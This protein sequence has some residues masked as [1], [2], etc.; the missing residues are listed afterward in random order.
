MT[1]DR[2]ESAFNAVDTKGNQY[3]IVSITKYSESLG[4]YESLGTLYTEEGR[5]ILGSDDLGWSIQGV[6]PIQLKRLE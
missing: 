2:I 4:N 5:L 1:Q 6:P 3:R